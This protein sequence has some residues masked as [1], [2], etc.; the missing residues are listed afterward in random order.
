MVGFASIMSSELNKDQYQRISLT[1][2]DM[3]INSVSKVDSNT[4]VWFLK[5]YN[6]A[7]LLIKFT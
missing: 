1:A 6:T 7:A 2:A 5:P 4:D 3:A